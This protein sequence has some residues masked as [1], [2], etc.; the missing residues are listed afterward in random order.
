MESLV[1]QRVYPYAEGVK[2]RIGDLVVGDTRDLRYPLRVEAEQGRWAC[3]SSRRGPVWIALC[4]LIPAE[5]A[6]AYF[7]RSLGREPNDTHA[8]F[9]RGMEWL[10]RDNPA[11]AEAD[12]NRLVELRPKLAAGWCL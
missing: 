5:R 12:V 4:E 11:R 3:V 9:F 1:G 7:T 10:E 2:L 6:V 8:L